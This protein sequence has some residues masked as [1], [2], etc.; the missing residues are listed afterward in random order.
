M[1]NDNQQND[2][3]KLRLIEEIL[4][5]DNRRTL[6]KVS[7]LLQGERLEILVTNQEELEKGV[8]LSE[9]L[10][11]NFEKTK[12][13]L[14]QFENEEASD[15]GSW[16]AFYSL[17]LTRLVSDDVIQASDC[18][19]SDIHHGQR[20][21]IH[22]EPVHRNGKQFTVPYQLGYLFA[23]CHYNSETLIKNLHSIHNRFGIP[24]DNIRVWYK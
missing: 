5:V 24:M 10:D 6:A 1:E 11:K 8:L 2:A 9:L 23:E 17:V 3:A 14:F 7:A 12:P 4:K 20:Y 21:A 22:T 19:I 16:K 13:Y 15:I 18:P